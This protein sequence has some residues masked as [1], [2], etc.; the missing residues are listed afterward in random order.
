M[1]ANDFA[2][3]M[4]ARIS[5]L[6]AKERGKPGQ[7]EKE[8]LYYRDYRDA[9]TFAEGFVN[10]SQVPIVKNFSGRLGML[11]KAGKM[12]GGCPIYEEVK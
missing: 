8:W 2:V 6:K 1:C 9:A 5:I 3:K 7:T 10:N 4:S 11:E 12:L